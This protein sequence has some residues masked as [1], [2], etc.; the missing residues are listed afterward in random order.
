M[1]LEGPILNSTPTSNT[2]GST[3]KTRSTMS[4]N[5]IVRKTK[6]RVLVYQVK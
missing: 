3:A 6:N 4:V 5:T 2:M 1:L